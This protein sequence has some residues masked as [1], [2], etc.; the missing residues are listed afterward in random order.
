MAVNNTTIMARAWLEGTNDFQQRIPRPTQSNMAQVAEELFSPLNGNCYNYFQDFLVNRI[1]YTIAHG[2]VFNNPL[3]VFKQ[4]KID[5]GSSIQ[6]VA[7]KWLKAHAYEDDIETLLKMNRP[8]GV[9]WYVSQNRR[10][11]Y[12]VTITHDELRT[13]FLDEYGLNNLAAKIVQLPSNSDEYDEFNIMKNLLS[14]YET[15]YGFTKH[16]LTAAPT[17]E[18]TGK[19]FLTAVMADSGMMQFPSTNYN[20]INVE[21]IPTFVNMDELILIV[22]PQTN[23]SIKVNTYAGLFN[24]SEAEVNARIVQ[25]DYLPIPNAVA[26]LTT[27]EIFDVH[28][29][30][31]EMKTFYN[32]QTLGTNYFLHHWG[33]YGLNPYVPAVLYTTDTATVDPTITENVTGLNITGAATAAAGDVVP[34]TFQL[35]GSVTPNDTPIELKPESVTANVT[36]TPGEDDTESA[37]NSR[38]YLDSFGKLHIQRTGLKA[39]STLTVNAVSTYVNPTAVQAQRFKASHT[40]TIQ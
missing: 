10:D 18:A 32:P 4:N 31:Y 5:Y 34:L 9:A 16:K 29:T 38:T 26:I 8:E 24:L 23:A 19:E 37:L 22:T 21:A 40:V 14:V 33:I 1:A 28:D 27:R 35:T 30:L 25:V 3:K 39:G 36:L 17:D 15:N 13:A 12:D 6:N 7:Y 20:A 11:R 2:R